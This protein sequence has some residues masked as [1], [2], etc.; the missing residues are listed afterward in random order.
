MYIQGL[1]KVFNSMMLAN[2]DKEAV[3]RLRFCCLGKKREAS[4][5][6]FAPVFGLVENQCIR[7]NKSRGIIPLF[8]SAYKTTLP[9]IAHLVPR[10]FKTRS[11]LNSAQEGG[12]HLAITAHLHLA[13]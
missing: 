6:P 10:W 8:A 3:A 4:R 2:V 9:V 13:R 11:A 7:Q 12:D 1:E 5:L